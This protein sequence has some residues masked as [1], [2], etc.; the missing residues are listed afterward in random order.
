MNEPVR[1]LRTLNRL[2]YYVAVVETGSFTAAAKQLGVTKAV[3]SDHIAKLEKEV[4]ATLLVRTT[5]KVFPTDAGAAFHNRCTAILR[6]CDE[7]FGELEHSSSA[8]R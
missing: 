1:P 2:V 4:G 8:P 7:A 3:V 5:R 6:Q